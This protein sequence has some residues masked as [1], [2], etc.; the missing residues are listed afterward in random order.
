MIFGGGFG[1]GHGSIHGGDDNILDLLGDSKDKVS[2]KGSQVSMQGMTQM[3]G[4]NMGSI[5]QEEEQNS[6]YDNS[7][8]D[9]GEDEDEDDSDDFGGYVP[10]AIGKVGGSA[11][12]PKKSKKKQ[13]KPP[14]T[15][16]VMGNNSGVGGPKSIGT[17]G[18]NSRDGDRGNF[19]YNN[20][21]RRAQTIN[22]EEGM[23][24]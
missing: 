23:Q 24:K 2:G 14:R 7:D 1:G 21:E 11:S 17:A 5:D 22:S 15:G 3:M 10:T 20:S 4:K 6:Q 9:G 19:D 13:V 18:A 16:G 12:K 8:Q